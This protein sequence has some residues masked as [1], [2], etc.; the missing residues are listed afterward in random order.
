MPT[1]RPASTTNER[2]IFERVEDLQ[3]LACQLVGP[4]GF[5]RRRHDV[6]DR[7]LQ[8]IDAHVAAQIAVGDDAG[9]LAV[10]LDDGDAA[11][12]LGRHFDDR[13]RHQR[14]AFDQRHGVAA[15]A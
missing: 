2:V 7:R 5:R 1:G 11:E 12:T 6:L 15:D 9:K 10:A 14:A 4:D 8:Q 3:R 13:L